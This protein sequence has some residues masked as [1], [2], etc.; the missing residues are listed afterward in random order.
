MKYEEAWH[1]PVHGGTKSQLNNDEKDGV[2]GTLPLGSKVVQDGKDLTGKNQM[3]LFTIARA[4]VLN[5]KVLNWCL[6]GAIAYNHDYKLSTFDSKI[7]SL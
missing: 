2:L 4:G 1:V 7:Y 5:F 6:S 3:L